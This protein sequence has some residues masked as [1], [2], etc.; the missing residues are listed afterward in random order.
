MEVIDALNSLKPDVE[1]KIVVPRKEKETKNPLVVC[2]Y[3]PVFRNH[4]SQ[5]LSQKHS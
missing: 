1:Q 4:K 2:A 5:S 3:V